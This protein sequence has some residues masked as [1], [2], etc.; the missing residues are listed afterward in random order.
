M[1]TEIS[2]YEQQAID[3]LNATNTEFS[4]EFVEFGKHFANDKEDRNVF[5]I[6]LKNSKDSYIFNFG[7]SI[8]DSQLKESYTEWDKLL[9]NDPVEIYCG[10]AM[11]RNKNIN[12]SVKMKIPKGYVENLDSKIIEK[13]ASEILN[14]YNAKIAT[15]NEKHKNDRRKHY[16]INKGIDTII[17][18]INRAISAKI[19]ELKE[20]KTDYIGNQAIPIVNPTAYDVLACLTKYDPGT[21][22]DFCS[23]FGYDEDSRNAEKTYNAVK[24]EWQNVRALFT[25]SEIEQ[26]QE[27]Q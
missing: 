20:V 7:S 5:Q 12:G 4:S 23:E 14:E 26:L 13:Y 3:F 18:S 6:T 19:K 24:D 21:F 10:I 11:Q 1:N 2:T 17:P 16:N 25:D 9:D 22:E 27:I 15:H 8:S